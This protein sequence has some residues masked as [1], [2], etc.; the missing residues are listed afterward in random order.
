MI[1]LLA[2]LALIAALGLFLYWMGW[3]QTRRWEVACGWTQ[4]PEVD[5]DMATQNRQSL[6]SEASAPR[7]HW[8]GHATMEIDWLGQRLIIDPVA[9]ARI[10][11][12]PRRFSDR[13]LDT[14]QHF[15]VILLSHA[16]MDHLDNPT[17]EQLPPSRIVLPPGTEDFLSEAVRQRHEIAP[18]AEGERLTLGALEIIPVPARHGGWRYP[19]QKGY[20]A[21]GYIVLSSERSLYLAGDTAMGPHFETIAHEFKPDYAVLPIGA[22]APQWFLRSRHLNPEEAW[23]AAEILGVDYLIPYHFGTYRLSLEAMSDPLIRFARAAKGRQA[24]WLLAE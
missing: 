14:T 16:H 13:R 7:L 3:G 11:I 22:Y 17:L 9:T 8:W 4:L 12:A 24:R 15:N 20:T 6:Q 1:L 18:L 5:R 10:K 23:Q 2:A 19:W 21:S